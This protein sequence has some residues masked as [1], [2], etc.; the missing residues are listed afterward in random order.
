MKIRFYSEADDWHLGGSTITDPEKLK[1]IEHTLEHV[2]AIIVQ[3]WH[4]RGSAAPDR[5]IF[6][7]YAE[8]TEWLSTKT[9]VGDAIDVW[10]WE[11][12]CLWEKRLA[13]GKCPDEQGRVPRK[14]AY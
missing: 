14:G 7:D 10:N 5:L 6:E 4:Y 2:G 3:H 13:E 8:F 11:E 1:R 9:S 12:V